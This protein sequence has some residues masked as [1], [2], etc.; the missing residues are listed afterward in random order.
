[1]SHPSSNT[2]VKCEQRNA[3]HQNGDRL[4]KYF[5]KGSKK[6]AAKK[7]NQTNNEFDVHVTVHRDKFL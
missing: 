5:N 4:F 2:Y 3:R 7:M 6:K 1:M